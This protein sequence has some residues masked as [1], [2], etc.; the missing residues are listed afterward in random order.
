MIETRGSGSVPGWGEV[1]LSSFHDPLCFGV[2]VEI[3]PQR[4]LQNGGPHA[5]LLTV[6]V[7]KLLSSDDHKRKMRKS[8]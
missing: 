5:H 4:F 6:E 2:Q 1:Y 7:S 3:A 8:D